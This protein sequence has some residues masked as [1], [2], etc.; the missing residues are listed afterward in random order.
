MASS[1]CN[2]LRMG[3]RA[4]SAMLEVAKVAS[5]TQASQLHTSGPVQ[6][7]LTMPERLEHIPDASVSGLRY[8]VRIL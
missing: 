4:G 8:Y 7:T 3:Q 5:S 1:L 6:G 2:A